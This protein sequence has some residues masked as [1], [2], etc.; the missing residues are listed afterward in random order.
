MA[1]LSEEPNTQ[2]E[3]NSGVLRYG[4]IDVGVNLYGV[5]RLQK[6]VVELKQN[7][8]QVGKAAREGNLMDDDLIRHVL[9]ALQKNAS[10]IEMAS[11]E[12]ERSSALKEMVLTWNKQLI[13]LQNQHKAELNAKMDTIIIRKNESF[14]RINRRLDEHENDLDKL[15]EHKIRIQSSLATLHYLTVL[16]PIGITVAGAII[17]HVIGMN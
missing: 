17:S 15:I 12:A 10:A 6:R 1:D 14:D 11:N 16:I 3:F 7:I 5:R 4:K 8:H 13:D 2:I 9:E